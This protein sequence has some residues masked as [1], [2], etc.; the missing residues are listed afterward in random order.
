MRVNVSVTVKTDGGISLFDSGKMQQSDRYNY[1]FVIFHVL[2]SKEISSWV[3][4][5]EL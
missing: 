3:W 2:V 1:F 5:V 4:F